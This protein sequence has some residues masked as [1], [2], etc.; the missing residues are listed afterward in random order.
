MNDKQP[1]IDFGDTEDAVQVEWRGMP[2]YKQEDQ[3]AWHQVKVSFENMDDLQEFGRRLG[4]SVTQKTR[5]VWFPPHAINRV[6]D[7]FY[8]DEQNDEHPDSDQYTGK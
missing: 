8:Y 6:S 2:E 3:T 5:A 7:L 1:L 4:V